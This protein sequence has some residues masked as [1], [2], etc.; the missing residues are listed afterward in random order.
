VALATDADDATVDAALAAADGD[1][2]VAIVALLTGV[3]PA[4]ARARLG[5]ARGSIRASLGAA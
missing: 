4:T 2:K 5:A 3:D 1:V